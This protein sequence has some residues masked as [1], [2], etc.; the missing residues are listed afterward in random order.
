M[1]IP[2]FFY[3]SPDVI[4]RE[5]RRIKSEIEEIT[6]SLNVREL[7]MNMLTECLTEEPERWA[8]SVREL[9]FETEGSFNK[10]KALDELLT[11]LISEWRA[12]KCAM[13]V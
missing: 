2:R 5:I 10:F 11:G 3:R 9:V 12:A 4:K 7:L 13:L 8:A 1:T 6:E